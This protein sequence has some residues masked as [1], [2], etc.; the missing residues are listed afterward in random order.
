MAE[1]DLA[2]EDGLFFGCDPRVRQAAHARIE[3][4]GGGLALDQ[5]AQAPVCILKPLPGRLRQPDRFSVPGDVADVLRR[6]RL[7]EQEFGH[8]GSLSCL[9]KREL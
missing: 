1:E 3:S 4:V 5:N 9:Y 8:G 6:E 2:G 7:I